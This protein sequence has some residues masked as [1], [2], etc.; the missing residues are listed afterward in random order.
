MLRLVPAPMHRVALRLAHRLRKRWWRMRRPLILG[1]RVLALDGDGRVLLI[2]HSYGSPNWMLPGGGVRRKEASIA[3]A[4]REL[5]EETA[6][7]LEE[8]R[9]VAMF[10]ESLFG[11]ANQV[12]VIAGRATGAPRADGRE[13]VEA[14]FFPLDQLPDN[15]AGGLREAIPV[16]A[17]L[18]ANH[19]SES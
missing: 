7:R 18:Y 11:A 14:R 8:P 10:V 6:C 15:L 3:A 19:S 17:A 13:V 9:E 1:C 4:L 12:H 16:W 5:R 2:R